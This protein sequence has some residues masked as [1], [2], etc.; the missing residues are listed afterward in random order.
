VCLTAC[1]LVDLFLYC[2]YYYYYYY[3]YLTI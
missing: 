3:Y 2:Y 1:N